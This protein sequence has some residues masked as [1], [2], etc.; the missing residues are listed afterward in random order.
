MS[1]AFRILILQFLRP[2]S[3]LSGFPIA[4][5]PEVHSRMCAVAAAEVRPFPVL[6]DVDRCY[7]QRRQRDRQGRA[8]H[9]HRPDRDRFDGVLALGGSGCHLI[10]IGGAGKRCA[11]DGRHLSGSRAVDGYEYGA[12]RRCAVRAGVNDDILHI[13]RSGLERGAAEASVGPI[14]ATECAE[15]CESVC[16]G[17]IWRPEAGREETLSAE[18]SQVVRLGDGPRDVVPAAVFILGDGYFHSGI[19]GIDFR[20]QAAEQINGSVAQLLVNPGIAVGGIGE[21]G[22]PQR[23]RA[24]DDQL[25]LSISERR[26]RQIKRSRSVRIVLLDVPV[27][28]IY[29]DKGLSVSCRG[30]VQSSEVFVRK[31]VRAAGSGAQLALPVVDSLETV[32]YRPKNDDVGKLVF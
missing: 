14:E 4:W 16:I 2:V 27:K 3:G 10:Q 21:R 22:V 12:A 29:I 9:G 7:A 19:F 6:V 32:M 25:D 23:A 20:L 1:P 13:A 8:T 17:S 31:P 28:V 11:S 30:R 5:C 24:L 26:A 15:A 18:N